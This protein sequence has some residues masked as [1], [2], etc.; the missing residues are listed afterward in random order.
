MLVV[1]YEFSTRTYSLKGLSIG[2]HLCNYD[3]TLWDERG[4][5]IFYR[6]LELAV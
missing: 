4:N 2:F 3:K 5:D 6:A 1:I